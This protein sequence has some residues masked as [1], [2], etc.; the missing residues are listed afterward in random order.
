MTRALLAPLVAMPVLLLLSCGSEPPPPPPPVATAPT[1]ATATPTSPSPTPTEA[2]TATPPLTATTTPTPAPSPPATATPTPEPTPSPVTVTGPLLV[3]SETWGSASRVLVY[4]VDSERYWIALDSPRRAAQVVGTDLVVWD[5]ERAHRVRRISLDGFAE[6]TLVEH[7]APLNDVLAS[8]DGSRVALLSASTLN[9]V[10]GASGQELRRLPLAELL[11]DLP[12]PRQRRVGLRWSADSSSLTVSVLGGRRGDWRT[13][14]VPLDGVPWA[15]PGDWYLSPDF[16]YALRP[17]ELL[18]DVPYSY[19][20][21]DHYERLWKEFDVIEVEGGNVLWTVRAKEGDG[22]IPGRGEWDHESGRFAYFE[23]VVPFLEGKYADAFHSATAAR[24]RWQAQGGADG[25]APRVF[26]LAAGKSRALS[27]E[28]WVEIQ[29]RRAERI[30]GGSEGHQ[31]ECMLAFEGRVVR[32][33][34]VGSGRLVELARP[35]TVR[36]ELM[37]APP[38]LPPPAEP[39]ARGDMVG[40]LLVYTVRGET[41]HVVDDQGVDRWHEHTLVMAYDEGAGRD[42]LLFD[43]RAELREGIRFRWGTVPTVQVARGG[44]VLLEAGSWYHE[45]EGGTVD[46]LAPDGA[47]HPLLAESAL[48]G[49]NVWDIA[50][51]PD[52]ATVAVAFGEATVDIWAGEGFITY[53]GTLLLFDLPSG[54]ES[55]RREFDSQSLQSVWGTDGIVEL[56][57]WR[58]DGRALSVLRS[59][60]EE[61][62]LLGVAFIEDGVFQEPP[63]GIH[64]EQQLSPDFRHAARA[65]VE[66]GEVEIVEYRTG[67]VLPEPGACPAV[68]DEDM[69]LERFGYGYSDS[70]NFGAYLEQYAAVPQR[71][72]EVVARGTTECPENPAHSCRILLD[73]EV[74]GEGRW[75]TII[76]IVELEDAP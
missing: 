37:A 70:V 57:T 19:G 34:R 65:C 60:Y 51:S 66:W 68:A 41:E 15:L 17:G 58:R 38:P 6:A 10:D 26:D 64:F 21:G 39:P 5:G 55:V 11:Q 29:G 23:Y 27:R 46:F 30:C 72:P 14:M 20:E 42:W 74:V 25:V 44:V 3:F 56:G 62:S 47:A 36:A 75:P 12:P 9:V 45:V 43:H 31:P 35:M 7:E 53:S 13:V 73:G 50:V 22:I 76:G 16:R 69:T 61:V 32:E 71:G 49:Q 67:R 59:G 52:A 18:L 63:E 33:G 24:A 4:D 2:V 28:E 8:P 54:R 40:P 1:Q 48:S